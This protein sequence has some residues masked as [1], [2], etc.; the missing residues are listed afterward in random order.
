M[1][2]LKSRYRFLTAPSPSCLVPVAGQGCDGRD[3][4]LHTLVFVLC[5]VGHFDGRR[6]GLRVPPGEVENLQ[7]ESL[8]DVG[9]R[10]SGML[11]ALGHVQARMTL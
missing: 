5:T 9:G 4:A 3:L 7:V 6:C 8:P 10:F 2:I 11:E 1:P